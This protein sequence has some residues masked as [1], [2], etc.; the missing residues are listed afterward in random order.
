MGTGEEG[1]GR[2]AEGKREKG[3]GEER[4]ASVKNGRKTLLGKAHVAAGGNDGRARGEGQ[5]HAYFA[6]RV[7]D[8]ARLAARLTER[9]VV[10]DAERESGRGALPLLVAAGR[11]GRVPA[12]KDCDRRRRPGAGVEDDAAALLLPGV[13]VL[14]LP[15]SSTPRASRTAF[16]SA[17]SPLSD[18]RIANGSAAECAAI[19]KLG[20][21]ERGTSLCAFILLS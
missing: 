20:P 14:V 6:L 4:Q 13:A 18:R 2:R 15:P 11:E 7:G 10:L 5:I 3:R 19:A 8:E 17:T 9:E 21:P 16:L 12:E 1:K